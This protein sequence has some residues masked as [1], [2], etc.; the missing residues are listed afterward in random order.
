[1]SCNNLSQPLIDILKATT[2]ITFGTQ[3]FHD[4]V[5]DLQKSSKMKD[6]EST[7]ASLRK[8]LSPLYYEHLEKNRENERSFEKTICQGKI[9]VFQTEYKSWKRLSMSKELKGSDIFNHKSLSFILNSDQINIGVFYNFM[10]KVQPEDMFLVKKELENEIINGRWNEKTARLYDW[11]ENLSSSKDSASKDFAILA[12]NNNNSKA[13]VDILKRT[14][15]ASPSRRWDKDEFRDAILD[16]YD[17]HTNDEELMKKIPMAI[18]SLSLS[19]YQKKYNLSK[20]LLSGN[21]GISIAP[22]ITK[23]QI[24][25]AI[26]EIDGLNTDNINKLKKEFIRI[27]REYDLSEETS[28]LRANRNFTLS[29]L[30]TNNVSDAVENEIV[31]NPVY[32]LK[33]VLRSDT[34]TFTKV[35]R[36]LMKNNYDVRQGIGSLVGGTSKMMDSVKLRKRLIYFEKLMNI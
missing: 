27:S 10:E 4:Y 7:L 8:Q 23:D 16:Y 6:V 26:T 13:L 36:C 2:P 1:M 31:N 30:K 17:R 29:F 22:Y 32:Y 34:K 35:V 28:N 18:S 9:S 19:L 12:M 24:K 25:E 15:T 11:V 14:P 33:K 5:D 21:L 3:E 20:A